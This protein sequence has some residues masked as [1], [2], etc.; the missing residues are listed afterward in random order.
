MDAGLVRLSL[1]SGDG[2]L[3]VERVTVEAESEVPGDLGR[4]IIL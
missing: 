4:S 1:R 2:V 3:L